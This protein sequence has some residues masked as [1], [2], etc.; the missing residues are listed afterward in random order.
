MNKI[1]F[2]FV[3]KDIESIIGKYLLFDQD[4][5]KKLYKIITINN[6]HG[7]LQGTS[8]IQSQYVYFQLRKK[9]K[10]T[11]INYTS[12]PIYFILIFTYK[13]NSDIFNIFNF[14]T[15]CSMSYCD[16]Q[17]KLYIPITNVFYKDIKNFQ[18][19]H[20]KN[21]WFVARKKLIYNFI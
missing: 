15:Y 14:N 8:S 21:K 11:Y 3:N 7:Y 18:Y 17:V 6:F 5:L 13:N 1:L 12:C 2:N 10:L 20:V 19:V 16:N 9:T 4:K